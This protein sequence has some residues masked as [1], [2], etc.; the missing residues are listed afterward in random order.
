M[1]STFSDTHREAFCFRRA[2]QGLQLQQ[3]WQGENSK[4]FV[5][6]SPRFP[7]SPGSVAD[8]FPLMASISGGSGRDASSPRCHSM[9][10]H[11]SPLLGALFFPPKDLEQQQRPSVKVI[12]LLSALIRHV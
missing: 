4:S 3:H 8:R 6:S 12:H 2:G 10:C 5:G 11:P 7:R 1:L 9:P